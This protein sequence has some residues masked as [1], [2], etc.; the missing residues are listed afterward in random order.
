M[1][2]DKN[3]QLAFTCLK[4]TMETPA[5][6][7]KIERHQNDDIIIKCWLDLLR[8]VWLV[9]WEMRN[10]K[11]LK[12]RHWLT[13]NNIFFAHNSFTVWKVSKYWVFSGPYFPVF[14]L[15]TE[16]QGVNLRIH[17]EYRKMRTRQNSV[18]GYFSRSDYCLAFFPICIE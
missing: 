11:E 12:T 3:K 14:G 2:H 17:S 6:C 7:V 10:V 4:R 15:N 8:E 18:F 1:W 13:H 16:I 9:F 5:Q